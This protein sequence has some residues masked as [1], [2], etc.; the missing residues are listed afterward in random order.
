[1]EK[2]LERG[3]EKK[4]TSTATTVREGA[5]AG[6]RGAASAGF[7]EGLRDGC[8]LAC[9]CL[10]FEIWVVYCVDLDVVPSLISEMTLRFWHGKMNRR[11]CA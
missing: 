10:K 2:V 11:Q 7:G 3:E 8:H 9:S 5:S 4:H 6:G 1:M